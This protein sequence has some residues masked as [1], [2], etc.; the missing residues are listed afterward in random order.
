M[1]GDTGTLPPAPSETR[2][3]TIK[4]NIYFM[5]LRHP[6]VGMPWEARFAPST[7][8]QM[9]QEDLEPLNPSPGSA[10]PAAALAANGLRS[11]S[12][13]KPSSPMGHGRIRGKSCTF[14]NPNPLSQR[15]ARLP[16]CRRSPPNPSWRA[17]GHNAR[18]EALPG[19]EGGRGGAY[20]AAPLRSARRERE[21]TPG[22][23]PGQ[24]GTPGATPSTPGP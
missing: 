2:G 3:S 10:A 19:A 22:E 23:T 9:I 21:Q 14:S 7:P 6:P 16:A 17:G 11:S 4:H 24:G 13:P 12:K 1:R 20:R 8:G 15:T 5:W 18:T